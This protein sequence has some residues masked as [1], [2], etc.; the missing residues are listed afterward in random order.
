MAVRSRVTRE[1]VV[2]DARIGNYVLID[3]FAVGG[4]A[5]IFRAKDE[6][7]KD[8]V[9]IKRMRPEVKD[10]PVLREGFLRETWLSLLSKHPNLVDG[11]E[12]G[13]LGGQEYVILEYVP[14]VD[15][16]RLF[17]RVRE[18]QVKVPLA[19]WL[20]VVHQ[21]LLALD[22][23]H[24]LKDEEDIPL[25][26][27]HRDVNPGNVLINFQGKVKLADFGVAHL[28]V[29]DPEPEQVVGTPGYIAPEQASLGPLDHRA[30]FFSLGCVMYEIL[31]GE[32][33]FNLQGLSDEKILSSHK[34]AQM[35]TVP[36]TVPDNL[37]MVVEIACS[38]HPDDRYQN[39]RTMLRDL[40]EALED[41]GVYGP[42]LG[43]ATVARQL[44]PDEFQ[45]SI[46]S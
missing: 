38:V 29:L 41:T 35:K 17:D 6:D 43:L 36:R 2:M 22:F 42:D 12:Q 39:A 34:K 14:G 21:V 7:K 1:A 32:R 45:R 33:A 13:E 40:D 30:D 24:D 5:E 3:R 27:V 31:T 4:S 10:D 46:V 19:F 28:A 44:F 23:A 18:R 9:I 26:L 8:I 16:R 37:R 15:L 20:H 11:I 25:G